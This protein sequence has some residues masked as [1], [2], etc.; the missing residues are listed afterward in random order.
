MMLFSYLGFESSMAETGVET[1]CKF[2]IFYY[3]CYRSV[4]DASLEYWMMIRKFFFFLNGV[5]IDDGLQFEE[6]NPKFG[7]D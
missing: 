2:R 5:T 4:F 1:R 7:S 6:Q 3:I